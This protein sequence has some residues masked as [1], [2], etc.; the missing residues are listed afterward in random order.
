MKCPSFDGCQD[1]LLYPPVVED[2]TIYVVS[3]GWAEM[4]RKVFPSDI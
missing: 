2:D 3:K 4:I 1:H